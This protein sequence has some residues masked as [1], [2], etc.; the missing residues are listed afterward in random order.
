ML[1]PSPPTYPARPMN[2]GRLEK[3]EPLDVEEW[4]YRP[5]YNGRRVLLHL[6]TMRT[7]NRQLEENNWTFPALKKLKEIIEMSDLWPPVLEWLD[8][9]LL[10]G[11]TS[12]GK[13]SVIVL[14]YVS[15]NEAWWDRMM[16]LN[17]VFCDHSLSTHA[18]PK[19]DA[20]YFAQPLGK[21]DTHAVWEELQG[22]NKELGV[23]F[24][25]GLVACEMESRY[26]IQLFSP[27]K[28][29]RHWIKYRFVN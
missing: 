23:T 14:D 19:D 27:K 28:E 8:L 2:G 13:R 24:Y 9:E 7:W 12:V 4:R 5:K 17:M 29:T 21:A 16:N 10:Y 6:P 15:A 22:R 18:R 20:V 1:N 11:K 25:E 26:P 3:A